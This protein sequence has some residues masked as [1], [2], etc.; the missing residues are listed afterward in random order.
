MTTWRYIGGS[1]FATQ[2]P[3]LTAPASSTVTSSPVSVSF[4]LPEA[5]VPG[6]SIFVLA[7][8]FSVLGDALREGEGRRRDGDA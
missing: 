3:T 4:S 7:L 5:A 2:P 8:A 6:L 1:D